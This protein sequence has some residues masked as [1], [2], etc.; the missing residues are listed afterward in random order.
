MKRRRFLSSMAF[1]L[2]GAVVGTGVFFPS[3]K[4]E[5][6]EGAF[7]E[8]DIKLLD[9]IG[10]TI[11]PASSTSPGAKAA[12][13]GEF[14]KVYVTDCYNAADRETFIEGISSF[15]KLSKKK[16]GNEFLKLTVSQKQSLLKALEKEAQEHAMAKHKRRSASGNGDAIQTG[17]AEFDDKNKMKE[18]SDHYFTMIKN[19]T[20]FGYFT[21]EPGATKA[22][23]YIQTPGYFAGDIPYKKGDKSWAS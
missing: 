17:K 14:M 12:K 2:P 6:K 15:K 23:R 16:Y 13:I 21:S 22:L 19:I 9:E 8:D 1:I 18:N 4:S 20:L 5:M 11:I 10:E 7:T 3:C